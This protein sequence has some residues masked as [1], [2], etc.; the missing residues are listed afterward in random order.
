MTRS[1]TACVQIF[2][3]TVL[4]ASIGPISVATG[5]EPTHRAD[6]PHGNVAAISDWALA[7]VVWGDASFSKKMAVAA[8]RQTSDP[9]R[10]ADLKSTV[11]R[12]D[13]IIAAMEQFGWRQ[14][15]RPATAAR[16]QVG[17]A[18]TTES[19]ARTGGGETSNAYQESV[20]IAKAIDRG[21]ENGPTG[22]AAAAVI[23]QYS[24]LAE[25][26]R[27]ARE[28]GLPNMPY[29]TDSL[30]DRYLPGSSNEGGVR[31][32]DP[33]NAVNKIVDGEVDRLRASFNATLDSLDSLDAKP[34]PSTNLGHYTSLDDET[35]ADA[36]WVQMQLDTNQI[37][38]NMIGQAKI[39]NGM[40]ADAIN[41]LNA[42]MRLAAR[43]TNDA[44]LKAALQQ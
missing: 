9:K 3:A 26:A 35:Q 13:R 18:G 42:R 40:L 12:L 43:I 28:A 34:L 33:S 16:S 7:G 32:L 20:E 38:W 2:L 10:L 5:D 41:Q 37:R 24:G 25:D 15:E 36:N 29:S 39:S 22:A 4:G 1:Q 14:L 23:K 8:A 44:K 11:Q 31:T 27:G 19:E 6:R 30:Y 17:A 21:V